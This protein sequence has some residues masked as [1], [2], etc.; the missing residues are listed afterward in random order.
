MRTHLLEGVVRHRRAAP[1]RVRARARRPL[2]G[3]RPRRARRRR[4]VVAAARPEPTA[5]SWSVRDDDHLDPPADGPPGGVPRPPSGPGRG[6]DRLADHA[7]HEP[8]GA[9]LRLQSGQLLSLS[10]RRR[11]AS[12]RGRGGP[13]HPRRAASLHAAAAR[14]SSRRSSPPWARRSTSRR[15][16]RRDGGYTVRV[17]DEASRLRITINQE[18]PGWPRRC[19]RA[20]ISSVDPLTDR[21][22]AADAAAASARDPQDHPDDPLARPAP[23]ASRRS[24]PPTSRGRPMTART[25]PSRRRS[26]SIP[27]LERAAWRVALAAAERIRHGRLTVVLPDGS[28]T[29]PRRRRPH[30]IRP[31]STST[32]GRR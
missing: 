27:L 25:V 15:S 8:A 3:A 28:R 7:R 2:R 32:T 22:L 20:W 11:R 12:G 4:S 26:P 30:P 17:R 23:V 31:R 13:Q 14:P 18:Q 5:A 29:R 19:T 16:S 1:V 9:R 6:P 10:R 24:I 21:N